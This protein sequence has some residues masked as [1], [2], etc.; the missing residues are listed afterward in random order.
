MAVH[1]VVMQAAEEGWLSRQWSK[2]KGYASRAGTYISDKVDSVSRAVPYVIAGAAVLGALSASPKKAEA[3]PTMTVETESYISEYLS[4]HPGNELQIIYTVTNTTL[5]SSSFDEM[6]NFKL[7]AGSAQ[8]VYDAVAPNNWSFAINLDD[9][10]FSA[11]GPG[12]YIAPSG[13]EGVFELYST[14]LDVTQKD[15]IAMSNGSGAFN[16]VS[17]DVPTPEPA[18]LALMAAGLAGLLAKYRRGRG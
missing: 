2:V 9:T 11:D 12:A 3:S 4:S 17:V 8:G 13:G 1:D 10:L 5:G 16:P 6:I 18:T 7:P 15:A 14:F